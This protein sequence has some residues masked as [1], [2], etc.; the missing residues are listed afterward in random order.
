TGGDAGTL[1][2]STSFTLPRR[3][4]AEELRF[5][6]KSCGSEES[7]QTSHE[8]EH[9]G[10]PLRMGVPD[11]QASSRTLGLVPPPPGSTSATPRADG[12][13]PAT[14]T[15]SRWGWSGWAT[16]RPTADHASPESSAGPSFSDGHARAPFAPHR[17]S[18]RRA[19]PRR[20]HR[21]STPEIDPRRKCAHS[22][23]DS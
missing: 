15:V 17:G 20:F 21:A 5:K 14:V 16:R 13:P 2:S 10:P 4:E 8:N 1:S 6:N 7:G 22:K 11:T 23:F 9:G 12:S 18:L 3:T 19:S